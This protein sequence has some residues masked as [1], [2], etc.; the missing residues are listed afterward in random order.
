MAEPALAEL[1]REH[2][3][4]TVGGLLVTTWPVTALVT[5]MV[6]HEVY[7]KRHEYVQ[8]VRGRLANG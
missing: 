7:T 3:V 1:M 6:A 8:A 2:N 5:S 4:D